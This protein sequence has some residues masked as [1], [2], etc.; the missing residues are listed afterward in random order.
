M[1]VSIM[2]V[3]VVLG[4]L[5]YGFAGNGKA[6]ELGRILFFCALFWLLQSVTQGHLRL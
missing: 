1:T 2:F 6:Q 4:A 3:L 5:V